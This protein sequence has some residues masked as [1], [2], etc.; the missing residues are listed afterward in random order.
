MKKWNEKTTF[1][2]VTE[3][4]SEIFLV[5]WLV[6]EFM[7]RKGMGDWTSIASR[8]AI[9]L[10]CVFS[11]FTYWNDKRVFSYVAIGGTVLL[12]ATFVLEFVIFA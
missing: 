1:E 6:F 10:V 11:C 8:V 9:M 4:L 2:K 12:L 5:I 7:D 3:V